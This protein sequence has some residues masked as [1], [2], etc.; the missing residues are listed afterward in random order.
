MSK[1]ILKNNL[2]GYTLYLGI[3][4]EVETHQLKR[5]IMEGGN[6][7]RVLGSD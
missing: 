7:N 2:D 1:E 5:C 6:I 4:K 3:I